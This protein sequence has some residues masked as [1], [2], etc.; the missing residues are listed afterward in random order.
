VQTGSGVGVG[1]G[2]A[3]WPA[4]VLPMRIV[5]GSSSPVMG[6]VETV[7]SVAVP[8]SAA[9]PLPEIVTSVICPVT[10]RIINRTVPS[11]ISPRQSIVAVG[12]DAT[13]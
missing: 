8:P 2:D 3:G 6:V 5:V 13:S 1:V 10:E 9:S 7:G 12:G 11:A 4:T